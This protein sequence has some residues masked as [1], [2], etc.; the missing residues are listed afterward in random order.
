MAHDCIMFLRKQK[1]H[2][3][4]ELNDYTHE[5]ND[6]TETPVDRL[7]REEILNVVQKL[8]DGY[9]TIFNMYVIDGF[10]HKEIGEQLGISEGTS[11]SQLFKARKLLQQHLEVLI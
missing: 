6:P 10:S 9:R 5:M 1:R 3:V 4:S 7:G 11:K 2:M 8:P